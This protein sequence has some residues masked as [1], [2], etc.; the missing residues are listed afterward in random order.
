MLYHLIAVG[1]CQLTAKLFNQAISL[2]IHHHD[3]PLA[4]LGNF[5]G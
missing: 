5:K 2:T 4:L 3:V 1:R